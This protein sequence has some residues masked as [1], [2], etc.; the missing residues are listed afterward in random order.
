M[1]ICAEYSSQNDMNIL[2]CICDNNLIDPD[3][4]LHFNTP[5]RKLSDDV[6][7]LDRVRW[8]SRTY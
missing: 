6:S 7:A 1:L 5:T 8:H 2:G 3:F 4:D